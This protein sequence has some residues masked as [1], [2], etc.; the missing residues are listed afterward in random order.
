LKRKEGYRNIKELSEEE[1]DSIV[2]EYFSSGLTIA[3]LGE[4]FKLTNRTLPAIL[5]ERKINTHKLNR[6]TLDENF[7][8]SIDTEEKAYWLGFLFA[9]GFVGDNKHNNVV[10]S[11]KISDKEV[12]ENFVAAI[13]FTGKMRCYKSPTGF[14][15]GQA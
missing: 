15:N 6:Y 5:K 3:K 9:D 7:F 1:K 8:E 4:K 10:F 13:K 11:Q 12:V 14:E 2:N